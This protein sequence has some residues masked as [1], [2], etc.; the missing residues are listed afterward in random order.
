MKITFQIE[1]ISEGV[2]EMELGEYFPREAHATI[3]I[4]SSDLELPLDVFFERHCMPLIARAK[5][6][7]DAICMQQSFSRIDAIKFRDD[8]ALPEKE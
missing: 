1:N 4:C 7:F 3:K 8:S 5:Q 2:Q 6:E